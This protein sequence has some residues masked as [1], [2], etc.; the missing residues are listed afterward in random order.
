MLEEH[1][2]RGLN[3][4]FVL[5]ACSFNL[6]RKNKSKCNLDNVSGSILIELSIFYSSNSSYETSCPDFLIDILQF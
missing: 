5:Q 1:F 2:G 6:S 3:L 4:D